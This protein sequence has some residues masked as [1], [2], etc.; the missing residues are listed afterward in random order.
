MILTINLECLE[1][2]IIKFYE[3]E[4]NNSLIQDALIHGFKIVNSSTYGLN[5]E[6]SN[7]D[8]T[9]RIELLSNQNSL[10]SQQIDDLKSEIQNLQT[11]QYLQ[12]QEYSQ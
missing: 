6:N 2:E 11:K 5:F 12:I 8:S 3:Q 4:S 10:L 7:Q 9:K 1:P